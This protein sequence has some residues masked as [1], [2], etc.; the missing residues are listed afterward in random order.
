MNVTQWDK[1]PLK[2]IREANFTFY[3]EEKCDVTS[4]W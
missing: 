4:P 3:R 2:G 1:P